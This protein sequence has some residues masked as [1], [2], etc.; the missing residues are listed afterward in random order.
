MGYDPFKA[1]DA[2]VKRLKAKHGHKIRKVVPKHAAN[3]VMSFGKLAGGISG[4]GLSLD[5]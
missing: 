1:Q 5:L 3:H 4:G 2:Y